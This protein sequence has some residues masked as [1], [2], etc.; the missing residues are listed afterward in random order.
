MPSWLNACLSCILDNGLM[1]KMRPKTDGW[2]SCEE[3]DISSLTTKAH[4][5]RGF[6]QLADSTVH[7]RRKEVIAANVFMH[8]TGNRLSMERT[9]GQLKTVI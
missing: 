7:S 8:M 1:F 6:R 5:R 4:P 2:S 3:G 9:R